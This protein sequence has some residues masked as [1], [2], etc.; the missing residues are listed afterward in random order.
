M[1]S[2]IRNQFVDDM[3][4][5]VVMKRKWV[6]RPL[7]TGMGLSALAAGLLLCLGTPVQ[8][9]SFSSSARGTSAASFLKLPASARAVALGDAMTSV[10]GDAA[11]LDWNPAGLTALKSRHAIL[12]HTSFTEGVSHSQGYFAQPTQAGAWGAGLSYYSSG[13]MDETETTVGDVVGSFHPNDWAGALGY[14]R[15]F[16]GWS[17]GVAGKYV[18]TTVV[19]T[20]D[21]LALT[22]GLL[23]PSLWNGRLVFGAAIRNAGGTLR[24]GATGRSLPTEASVGGSLTAGKGLT[25]SADLK[26]PRDNDPYAALGFEAAFTPMTDWKMAARAGWNGGVDSSLGG[27]AGAAAGFGAAFRGIGIDY[28]FS[29]MGDLGNQ[30]R[31]S[32]SLAF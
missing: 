5:M 22:G 30:H 11:G 23:T 17:L 10:S 19:E 15:R 26:A 3:G 27:I 18:R 21:T 2:L 6:V 12:G 8:A 25:F 9:G 24:L 13:R 16:G 31:F 14:A 4:A 28:A 7:R 32:L 29:P 1:N 20:D